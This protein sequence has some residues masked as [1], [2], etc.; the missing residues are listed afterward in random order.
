VKNNDHTSFNPAAMGGAG[1][2]D[3][4][5]TM[6][7]GVGDFAAEDGMA[8]LD[9][10]AGG[11]S[12][13]KISAGSF[14]IVFVIAC[15]AAGLFFMRAL[16]RVSTSAS[17]VSEVELTIEKF[18]ISLKPG[19]GDA[20][21]PLKPLKDENVLKVLNES[22]TEQQIA[23]EDVQFNPFIL[24]GEED[25]PRVVPQGD[26]PAENERA[27][28][29]S[30]RKMKMEEAGARFQLK[31]VIMG[32]DP[33]ANVSGKIVRVGDVIGTDKPD[34][35]FTVTAVTSSSVVLLAEDRRLGVSV[36]LTLRIK[37]NQ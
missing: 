15:A 5:K 30:D 27:R 9:P 28:L 8:A 31:S 3:E 13:R 22:F 6:P 36:E 19:A 26:D 14:V 23:L 25:E 11:S 10:L 18:L 33:L 35:E 16:T 37:R 21:Q 1:D 29:A 20:A 2:Q 7:L 17:G 24:P 4:A 32:S 34:I 12:R